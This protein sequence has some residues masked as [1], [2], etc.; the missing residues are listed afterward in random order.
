MKRT[1]WLIGTLACWMLSLSALS[2]A[3]R[4][5]P[6]AVVLTTD[7]GADMDDQWVLAHLAVTP[8]VDLRGVIT[9]HAPFLPAP[10]AEFT[11][12]TA[13]DVLDHMPL[14]KHPPVFAGSSIALADSE[15]PLPNAGVDFLLKQSRAF[16][17]RHRLAVLV[18]GAAT[19]VASAL[20]MD[21]SLGNRIEIIAM[22]F[23]SWPEGDDMFN[24][25]NDVRAWQ[26]LLDSSSPITVGDATVAIRDLAMTAPHALQLFSGRG[27]SGTYLAGL[28][29]DWL[30]KR[31]DLVAKVG[32]GGVWPIWDEVTLAYLLGLTTQEKHPRPKMDDSTHLQPRSQGELRQSAKDIRWIKSIDAPKLW[33]HFTRNLDRA[34]RRT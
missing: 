27:S 9:T 5:G 1:F 18:I 20:R 12:K 33:D 2:Q 16:N 30:K 34:R 24:V 32:A 23:A 10:A 19:D 13:R 17:S 4:S 15:K 26:T 22:G 7:C 25:K 11:A 3:G 14:Q 6:R 31:P 8:E 21:P 28:F 29:T